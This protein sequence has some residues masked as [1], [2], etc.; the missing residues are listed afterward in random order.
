MIGYIMR[1]VDIFETDV[2]DAKDSEF[3]KL[4]TPSKQRKD[5]KRPPTTDE[6]ENS[7]INAI[8]HQSNADAV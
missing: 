8:W 2:V 4:P 7:I 1:L 6:K 5:K 3:V